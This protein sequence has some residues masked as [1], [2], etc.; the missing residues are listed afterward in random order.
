MFQRDWFWRHNIQQ[1]SRKTHHITLRGWLVITQIENPE[2]S[3]PINGGKNDF[4]D[5]ALVYPVRELAYIFDD[6]GP[7]LAKGNQ[8]VTVRA[9]YTGNTENSAALSFCHCFSAASLSLPRLVAGSA[10]VRSSIKPSF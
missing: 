5:I 6:P 4:G 3:R 1:L 7:S 2:G 10:A 9:V 8:R